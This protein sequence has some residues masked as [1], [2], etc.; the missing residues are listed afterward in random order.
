[1]C[2]GLMGGRRLLHTGSAFEAMTVS[3]DDSIFDVVLHSCGVWMQ[4][5]AIAI[6]CNNYVRW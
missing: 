3:V 5:K 2:S 4:M 1:M 6:A